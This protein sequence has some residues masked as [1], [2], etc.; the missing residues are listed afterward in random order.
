MMNNPIPPD[1]YRWGRFD[2][3]I[4]HNREILRE[5]LD[6]AAKPDPHRDADEQKI[7]DYYA[8]CMDESAINTSDDHCCSGGL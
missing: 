7:G 1:Q 2:E 4:Q 6:Q 8:A 5:I 3:L